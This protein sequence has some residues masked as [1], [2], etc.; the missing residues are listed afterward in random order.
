VLA[1][2]AATCGEALLSIAEYLVEDVLLVASGAAEGA[3]KASAAVRGSSAGTAAASSSTHGRSDTDSVR[4]N[5]S[6]KKQRPRMGG[7]NPKVTQDHHVTWAQHSITNMGLLMVRQEWVDPKALIGDC[8]HLEREG[9]VQGGRVA[10][11]AM[12]AW[13]AG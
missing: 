6:R 5:S 12:A 1:R 8:G 9:E 13:Q 7:R 10:A 2:F 3:A 11:V 4:D